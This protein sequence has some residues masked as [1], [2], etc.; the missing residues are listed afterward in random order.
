MDAISEEISR[1][2][3][4]MLGSEVDENTQPDKVVH[5]NLFCVLS[6]WVGKLFCKTQQVFISTK[7]FFTHLLGHICAA[8]EAFK[9]TDKKP[10]N[11]GTEE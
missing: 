2:V 3:L 9:A 7:V 4:I 10:C 6:S 8:F 1:L 5:I 11:N